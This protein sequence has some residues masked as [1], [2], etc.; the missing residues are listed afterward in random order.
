MLT[1]SSIGR[2]TP[3]AEGQCHG[4]EGLVRDFFLKFL[5]TDTPNAVFRFMTRFTEQITF[6]NLCPEFYCA[7]TINHAGDFGYLG[8]GVAVME[9]ELL[10]V[11]VVSAAGT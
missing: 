7:V 8:S 4:A 5:R 2:G 11:P 9:V 1:R 3:L 6:G 10:W